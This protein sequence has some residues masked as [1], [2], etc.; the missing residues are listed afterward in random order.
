MEEVWPY[1]LHYSGNLAGLSRQR[2]GYLRTSEKEQ[3]GHPIVLSVLLKQGR[4]IS[5]SGCLLRPS[6]SEAF[7]LLWFAL[8][9]YDYRAMRITFR[10]V[11]LLVM[12]VTLVTCLFTVLQVRRDSQRQREDVERRAALLAE[13]FEETI[14][15]LFEKKAAK[16][17][18]RIVDRF[19]NRERLSGVVVYDVSG[20]VMA[21]TPGLPSQLR[22]PP[23]IASAALRTGAGVG[24]F[25]EA[26]GKLSHIYALPLQQDGNV[27]AVLV[28]VHDASFI[29]RQAG[30]TWRLTFTRVLIQTLLITVV[31]VLLVRWGISG[32]IARTAEWMRRLRTGDASEL[33]DL[34]RADLFQPLTR[35]VVHLTE[36]LSAA[37]AAAEEE[38]RLREAAESLWT[39]ERL[40]EHVRGLLHGQPLFVISNREPYMHVRKGKA[41]ECLVPASG[42]VTALEPV[43]RACGGTWIAQGAGDADR[44]TVDQNDRLRV[45]PEDPHFTL[46]R[47]WLSKEEEE[48]YYYGFANEG[49]WPLCHIAHTRPAFKAEDWSYYEAVNRRFAA[50]VLEELAGTEN[51]HVLVQDYHFAL[52]PRL[53]KEQ[54]PDARV[55]IFW[56]IPWPNPEAFGICPWQKEILNG[57][58]GADLVGFHIQFHCNNFLETV[59][60]SVESRI[61][62]E[63][64]S[65]NRLGHTT[66]VKPFPISVALPSAPP[67]GQVGPSQEALRATLLKELGV[68]GSLLAV[69]VDRIDYTKGIIERFLGIERFLETYPA[70]QRQLVFVELGAPSRTHIPEYQDLVGRVEREA[71]RI[72]WRFQTRDWKPI[73]FL[74]A[75]HGQP[76]I[77]RYY[78][79]A[80]VCLVTS[81][82]DGMNLVAKEYVAARE[83]ERGVLILSCFTGASR[84]LTSALIVNPYDIEQ[85]AEAIRYAV[86]MGPEERN[87]RMVKLR[88]TVKEA[89]VYRWAGNL[90][91]ALSQVPIEQGQRA[92]TV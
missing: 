45:P 64:F 11:V 49:M 50:V 74:K 56:H 21:M 13:S 36:S 43:L 67:A 1:R 35:E 91:A 5:N 85:M 22:Q 46:R 52:L 60:R 42:L 15:L 24:D 12:G 82:H 69:G 33:R 17:L 38:A 54:R 51:P 62:W 70:Y 88:R 65:V 37:R 39:P 14:Q 3:L 4:S 44:D 59:D 68:T 20:L 28:L 79:A 77:H 29:L 80:D 26:G 41:I 23:G 58:L 8:R 76:E 57:L 86:E 61:D 87:S 75:H 55:A 47:V 30:A 10:L 90:V 71:E 16:D 66:R 2:W 81:L 72:N 84:E 34:P 83:D 48:G 63:T 40:R 27:M 7:V 92:E 18:Q 32:P 25:Q 19:G 9:E 53:I 78:Q 73:V 31:T 89:N 6:E